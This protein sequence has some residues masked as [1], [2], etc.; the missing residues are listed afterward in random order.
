MFDVDWGEVFGLTMSP[1][2][3]VVRG[4]AMFWFLYALFRFVLR[5]DVGSVGMADVLIFVIIADAAQNAMSGEY[6]SVSDGM[7]LVA[8]IVLW[9]VAVDWLAYRSAVLRRLLEPPLL[10]M[11]RN[12]RIN[13]RAMREQLMTID[14][15]KAKL[16]DHEIESLDEVKLAAFESN[17]EFSVI[18]RRGK[19]K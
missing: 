17:G 3:L 8:T 14:D 18:K 7:I 11:V 2:E 12:G 15:L 5:R 10:V 19:S 9:N 4:T 13:R 1:L 6:K 16:R